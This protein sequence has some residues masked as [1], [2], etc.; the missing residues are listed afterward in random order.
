MDK[1]NLCRHNATVRCRPFL[2]LLLLGVGI[3]LCQATLFAEKEN[4]T[5]SEQAACQ[6]K[7]L[8][9]QDISSGV[10]SKTSPYILNYDPK[11]CLTLHYVY[12]GEGQYKHFRVLGLKA[13]KPYK[14]KMGSSGALASIRFQSLQSLAGIFGKTAEINLKALKGSL[15]ISFS[16]SNNK[17]FEFEMRV[18]RG[19]EY[20][21]SIA[22]VSAKEQAAILK[23]QKEKKLVRQKRLEQRAKER[24]A[25][26]KKLKRMREERLQKLRKRRLERQRQHRYQKI[27]QVYSSPIFAHELLS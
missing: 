24:A 25:R 11:I 26:R 2:S 6:R 8:K 7:P 10:G 23:K 15:N 5:Q 3:C 14:F 9:F 20:A 21:F 18:E 13:K 17:G 16:G 12:K 27:D 22:A 19:A 4:L 1:N